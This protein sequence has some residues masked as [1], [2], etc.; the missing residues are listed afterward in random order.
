MD[1]VKMVFGSRRNQR[2]EN[3][4]STWASTEERIDRIHRLNRAVLGGDQEALAK[5]EE[6]YD[7]IERSAD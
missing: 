2:F 4:I 5:L 1:M 6:L 3:R 7:E